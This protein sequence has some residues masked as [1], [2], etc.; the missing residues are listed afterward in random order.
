MVISEP[1]T[2]TNFKAGG[3]VGSALAKALVK[4]GK[5]T[6]TAITREGSKSQI[7]AGVN[8][9][10]VN[11]DDEDSL[12]NALKGHQFVAISLAVM[13]PADTHAKLVKAAA[14]AGV[15]WVMPNCY[16]TDVANKTLSNENLTGK[17][18][19]PGIE[20]AEEA[21]ISYIVLSCGFWYEHS[22]AQGPT[23]FGFDVNK[24][25]ATL[26]DDGKTIITTSTWQQC[27][28]AFAALLS[29]K[30]LP[31]DENDKSPTISQWRNKLLYIKSF[32]ISQRDMLDSLQRVLG[33]TD[34][35]W[36]IDYEPSADR[37]KR[38]MGLLKQGDR[39]GYTMAMYSR[40]FFPNG[41][42]DSETKYGLANDELGLPKE[43][44]DEASKRAIDLTEGGYNYFTRH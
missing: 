27:G 26:Y 25:N 11:Y 35:D 44:L 16:G 29:L 7:P 28:R 42:A 22:V 40:T 24:R 36:T 1:V 8:V 38:A 18:V 32:R 17:G 31:E 30:E 20:A 34:K 6:V 15:P 23:F 4:T 9:V 3:S 33:E 10:K 43:D 37:Y 21:G 39:S 12:V 41:D 2:L 19:Y 5:H 14:K 13:A